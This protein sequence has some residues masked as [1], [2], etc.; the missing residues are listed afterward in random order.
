MTLARRIANLEEL[1]R[2]INS[3]HKP[4]EEMSDGE[5][6]HIVGI[7][8]RGMTEAELDAAFQAKITEVRADIEG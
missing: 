1:T 4:V 8:P 3:P 6:L 5:L 2:A 7:D